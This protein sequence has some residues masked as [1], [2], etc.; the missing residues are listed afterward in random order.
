[1]ERAR[2]PWQGSQSLGVLR[3]LLLSLL[4]AAAST[5]IIVAI[6]LWSNEFLQGRPRNVLSQVPTLV[7]ILSQCLTVMAPV[8]GLAAVIIH[9]SARQSARK[10][11][12]A[13]AALAILNVPAVIL[14]DSVI[15]SITG[16][17]LLSDL[18]A[19]ILMGHIPTL[20]PFLS[21]GMMM[22]GTL[23]GLMLVLTPLILWTLSG[24]V[25][26]RL[27]ATS[28]TRSLAAAACLFAGLLLAGWLWAAVDFSATRKHMR[29]RTISHPLYAFR[30]ISAQGTGPSVV[31]EE[32]ATR[33]ASQ[34]KQAA[35]RKRQQRLRL[36]HA[37]LTES[38]TDPP[39]VLLVVVESFRRELITQEVM[40]NL[41]QLAS[42]GINCQFHFSGGN[43]TNHGV[44]SLLS[45]LEPTWFDSPQRFTPTLN[46]YFRSLGYEVGFFAG[47][48]DWAEFHMDGFVRPELYDE[49]AAL[50]RNGLTSDRRAIELAGR[51][52]DRRDSDANDARKPRV[53][54][55]YLYAT[56]ATYQSYPRDRLDRPAA[57]ERYPFPYPASLQSKVWNRY[58]NS[59][60]TVDRLLKDLLTED[61]VIAVTGDHGESFLEDT[62]IG[63]GLRLS[64]FQNMTPAVFY[65]PDIPHR[66]IDSPTMH[67]D[68]LP[69]LIS[70]LGGSLSD[71]DAIDGISLPQ[72]GKNQLEQRLLATRNYLQP[73]YALIGPWTRSL[74]QPFAY[75][76]AASL[77]AG[78]ARPLNAI[79]E[80][81]FQLGTELSDDIRHAVQRW[82]QQTYRLSPTEVP[83][84]ATAV[85]GR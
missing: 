59:A 67:A 29:E 72:C 30:F 53:A 63:H 80:K 11:A 66:V 78:T 25:T 49:Y 18:A 1:M 45:G 42:R 43:A 65:A 39:D 32:I 10:F 76:V 3:L 51:F 46:R 81:G 44:F 26:R 50:D 37:V 9:C 74:N 79:D 22:T 8:V 33:T 2:Q 20:I 15:F 55:L 77:K 61:R 34:L 58:R 83:A 85:Q 75:R 36:S 28:P 60:R 17:R 52:L 27:A 70:L 69:T 6:A 13:M 4:S 24:H 47:A 38:T 48:N 82:Q 68:V 14:L 35:Y 64:S 5:G 23:I 71:A 12:F 31:G 62:T 41:F 16:E 73:D 84:T 57:D 21:Q 56:H 54:I 40:P 7:W 19:R